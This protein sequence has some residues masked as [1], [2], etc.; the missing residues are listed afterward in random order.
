MNFK[1]PQTITVVP[2]GMHLYAGKGMQCS[3]HKSDWKHISGI[4]MIGMSCS[5]Q[6]RIAWCQRTICRSDLHY[7]PPCQSYWQGTLQ[8]ST[9]NHLQTFLCAIT[10]SLLSF[11]L[12]HHGNG[13]HCGR[14]SCSLAGHNGSKLAGLFTKD[15]PNASS[16]RVVNSRHYCVMVMR[17]Q[18][19]RWTRKKLVGTVREEHEMYPWTCR[20]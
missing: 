6:S 18:S 7:W 15:V 13:I 16:V 20:N 1:F 9:C 3:H 12:A 8:T 5:S 11:T 10:L 4:V 19:I 14:W 2:S 17:R